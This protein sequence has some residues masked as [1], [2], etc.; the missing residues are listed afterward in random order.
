MSFVH[1]T[2]LNS[3]TSNMRYIFFNLNGTQAMSIWLKL[4][5][6]IILFATLYNAGLRAFKEN[7][8]MKR[9]LAVITF[10]ISLISTIFV[11]YNLLLF[12]FKTYSAILIIIFALLPGIIGFLINYIVLKGDEAY[13]KIIRAIIYFM[14]CI[15]VMGL[16]GAIRADSSPETAIYSLILDP[17]EYG[18]IIAFIIG[19]INLLMALVG[20]G[21]IGGPWNFSFGS[22]SPTTSA[23]SSPHPQSINSGSTTPQSPP[24]PNSNSSNTPTGTPSNISPHI[25]PNTPPGTPPNTPPNSSLTPRQPPPTQHPN[26]PGPPAPHH[27]PK[28]PH[29]PT[30]PIP[31]Q[32]P[33]PPR[34]EP[35]SQYVTPIT[36]DLS[37]YFL[38]IKNQGLS[39]A[40]AAFASGSVVEFLLN[41]RAQHLDFAH[42]ISSLYLWYYF[43]RNKNNNEGTFMTDIP[44]HVTT[45]GA[46]YEKIWTWP[47][48]GGD[49]LPS[50]FRS[51]PTITATGDGEQKKITKV[52]VIAPDNPDLW[53]EELQ[54]GNPLIIGMEVH[55]NFGA[56]STPALYLNPQGT[57]LGG[58]AMVIVGFTNM[59]PDPTNP[60]QSISVFKIRNSW[61]SGYGEFGYLWI[62]RDLLPTLMLA[63]PLVFEGLQGDNENPPENPLTPPNIEELVESLKS[64]LKALDSLK[65]ISKMEVKIEKE[66]EDLLS[67]LSTVEDPK[68]ATEILEE[69]KKKLALE[70]RILKRNEYIQLKK[71]IAQEQELDLAFEKIQL[72]FSTLSETHPRHEEISKLLEELEHAIEYKRGVLRVIIERVKKMMQ[73]E[74]FLTEV[75]EEKKKLI[76]TGKMTPHEAAQWIKELIFKGYVP[77]LKAEVL[78]LQEYNHDI[79]WMISKFTMVL[80]L[81]HK[82]K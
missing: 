51:P 36:I 22:S 23:S 1:A 24:Q 64:Q 8:Q 50:K 72:Y 75:V 13:K 18:V 54:K 29:N 5:L 69:I 70:D 10:L 49:N 4:A 67:E 48:L 46:C 81:L 58:H 25:P 3:V 20:N 26:W 17:L 28:P 44:P 57:S 56:I 63:P 82:E 62:L 55:Q 47:P 78:A 73:H 11:P 45:E 42:E 59:M 7:P 39:S 40:C 21:S 74:Q 65:K 2:L 41:I 12:I 76:S 27:D 43:R 60:S 32:I 30:F 52:R 61:G 71:I 16:I 53:V 15:F 79:D 6:F 14:I 33:R 80:K 77:N 37:P 38:P 19:I 9:A 31:R 34:P 68:R 66:L 35:S